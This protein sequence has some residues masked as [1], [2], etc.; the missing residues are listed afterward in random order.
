MTSDGRAMPLLATE[1]RVWLVRLGEVFFPLADALWREFGGPHALCIAGELHELTFSTPID[2]VAHPASCFLRWHLPIHH[3]WPSNPAKTDA[4]VEKAAQ[5]L[6]RK[7]GQSA[8]AN[9]LVTAVHA[10]SRSKAM[11]SNVR[12]R[13]L[14]VFGFEGRSPLPESVDPNAPIV[15]ALVGPKG[16]QA[17]ITTPRRAKSFYPGGIRFVRQEGD[18][19]VSRAGAKIVEGLTLLSLC[20]AAPDPGES[21][22]WLE[23]GA[24]PGGMT[25][26]LL[27]RGYKVTALDRAPLAPQLK[28]HPRLNFRKEDV[29]SYSPSSD[30]FFGGLLCDMNGSWQRSAHEVMRLTRYLLSGAPIVF[31]LKFNTLET[32]TA[33]LAAVQQISA[34]AE[35]VNV[36]TLMTTH[37]S[38]NRNELTCLFRKR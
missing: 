24:S 22:H 16:V 17:G 4:F 38:F 35:T 29:A 37:S 26:E 11:A 21:T 32:P 3:T 34:L 8:P 18:A 1:H 33:I 25:A 7:F 2:L 12:G 9:I 27:T 19:V 31:T 5:G 23:L 30:I 15:I 10:D 28:N 14:Q 36:A 6:H 20:H 13:A